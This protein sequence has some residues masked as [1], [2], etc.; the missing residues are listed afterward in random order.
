MK[1]NMK[2]FLT[3]TIPL[4]VVIGIA[5]F[6]SASV[7]VS[8]QD[9]VGED[10][11]LEGETSEDELGEDEVSGDPDTLNVQG[12]GPISTFHLDTLAEQCGVVVDARIH[13]Q[14]TNF[15]AKKDTEV[16]SYKMMHTLIFN[17]DDPCDSVLHS[18]V[19]VCVPEVSPGVLMTRIIKRPAGESALYYPHGTILEGCSE[20][21]SLDVTTRFNETRRTNMYFRSSYLSPMKR[22]KSFLRLVQQEVF[23]HITVSR[24]AN[25]L[26]Y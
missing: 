16:A 15:Y 25:P 4:M 7:P 9:G 5:I 3:Y 6:I 8:A 20:I 13:S 19:V 1:I 10:D 11:L 12:W 23:G 26:S 21:E 2:Y 18:T 14:H 22:H 17:E 24:V